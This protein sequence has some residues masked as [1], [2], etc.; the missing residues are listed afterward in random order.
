[1][2]DQTWPLSV[3]PPCLSFLS[4]FPLVLVPTMP[5][6]HPTPRLPYHAPP[7]H[8]PPAAC[9][10]LPASTS[11]TSCPPCLCLLSHTLCLPCL[12]IACPPMP[13]PYACAWPR[14]RIPHPVPA[15]PPVCAHL[16]PLYV[17]YGTSPGPSYSA[18]APAQPSQG[19]VAVAP[20]HRSVPSPCLT[21]PPFQSCS[22]W[23]LALSPTK[24]AIW[25]LGRWQLSSS[26]SPGNRAKTRAAL[27]PALVCPLPRW[28][29]YSPYW[30][31][32][33]PSSWSWVYL[34]CNLVNHFKYG[35]LEFDCW[36][37]FCERWD[38]MDF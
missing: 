24:R 35:K 13:L 38:V 21:P 23:P 27:L 6:L 26:F 36:L 15:T 16:L 20:D 28:G 9:P 7:C 31:V 3:L 22:L 10:L 14:L 11:P 25:H 19:K 4:I 2:R 30:L 17:L 32:E 1:M 8:V 33:K 37:M 5:L 29:F 12:L 34:V 18:A